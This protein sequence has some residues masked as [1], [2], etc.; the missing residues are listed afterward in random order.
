MIVKIGLLQIYRQAGAERHPF[1]LNLSLP[2]MVSDFAFSWALSR[3]PKAAAKRLSTLD[4]AHENAS[5][6]PW[7][8]RAGL[9][10]SVG[11]YLH[12]NVAF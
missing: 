1:A 4:K 3:A 11:A 8:I 5:V 6:E 9:T 2:S 7:K 12:F 10:L